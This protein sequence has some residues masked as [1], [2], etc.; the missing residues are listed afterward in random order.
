MGCVE[1]DKEQRKSSL[2]AI[3]RPLFEGENEDEEPLLY[4]SAGRSENLHYRRN[5]EKF[6]VGL[7]L[8]LCGDTKS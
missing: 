4:A 8:Q 6:V 5:D 7:N 1:Q 2:L 3:E